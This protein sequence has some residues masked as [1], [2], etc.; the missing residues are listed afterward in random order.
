MNVQY[1]FA[2]VPSD[3]LTLFG[4]KVGLLDKYLIYATNQYEYEMLLRKPWGDYELHTVARINTGTGYNQY[5]YDYYMQETND[6]SY[7][8]K[9]EYYVYSNIGQGRQIDLPIHNYIIPITVVILLLWQII[10]SLF[11]RIGVL[12]CKNE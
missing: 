5:R 6:I 1:E 10:K 3:V 8:I 2:T 7:A 11:G 9:E 12:R 4:S